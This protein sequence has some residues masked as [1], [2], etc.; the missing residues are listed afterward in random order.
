MENTYRI[1][2]LDM[3]AGVTNEGMRCIKL[4]AGQFLEQEGVKGHYD[5]FEVR[6]NNEIPE[7]EDYDIFISSGGPGSPL[8]FG[9]AWETPYFRFLDAI[10]THNLINQNKKFAFLICHSF[11]LAVLHWDLAKV[12]KRKSTSF[13]ILPVHKTDAGK[14]DELLEGLNNPFYAVDSR[15]YQVVRPD[16]RKIESL[17]GSILC[18]EKMRQQI[19]LERAVMAI[20]FSAEIVGVQFHPEADAEGMMRYFQKKEKRSQIVKRYGSKKYIQMMDYLDDDD[21]ILMTH[22]QIIPRF[23]VRAAEHIEETRYV[24][25]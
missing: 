21:K 13:G 7:I 23:L 16:K 18:K 24:P 5:I 19:H 6:T 25:L 8:V 12:T 20:R 3:N 4:I 10:L 17:G 2:I 11:Q 9:E 22:M 1:A 14:I 15:D